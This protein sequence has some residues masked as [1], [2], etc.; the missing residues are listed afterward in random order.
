MAS[1][2]LTIGGV[3]FLEKVNKKSVIWNT[4]KNGRP[5]TLNLQIVNPDSGIEI[6]DEVILKINGE[7]E[8]AGRI[9]RI[10]KNLE[11]I[12]IS[13]LSLE[14]LDYSRD[15]NKGELIAEIYKKQTADY[16]INDLI[17]RYP[18]LSEFTQNNVDCPE[19][20]DY[21]FI[22][23]VN[24]LDTLRKI[25]D[26]TGYDF[27]IDKNKDIH[28]YIVGAENAAFNVTDA[29][30]EYIQGTLNMKET[31]DRIINSMIIEGGLFD[32]TITS[33]ENFVAAVAQVEFDLGSYYSGY[34][35]TV[36]TISKTVGVFGLNEASEYD[37]LYD[38]SGRKIVFSAPLSG[39][40]VI[41]WSG[42][43]KLPVL[44]HVDEPNSIVTH[45]ILSKR[46]IDKSLKTRNSAVQRGLAEL[47][48][49]SETQSNGGFQTLKYGIRAGERIRI[50]N[51]GLGIDEDYVVQDTSSRI[52]DDV[53]ATDYGIF[54]T[55]VNVAKAEV[56][57]ATRILKQLLNE[58]NK[59]VSANEILILHK[60][61]QENIIVGDE[62]LVDNNKQSIDENI[63]IADIVDDAINKTLEWVHAPYFPSS[64]SDSKRQMLHDSTPCH[65]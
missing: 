14:C 63:Q 2:S 52:H 11:S 8:F 36:D 38:F 45:G 20:I 17:T 5:D 39:G 49:Y 22:G 34:S 4:N 18:Q 21:L 12:G 6:D 59:S 55:Q 28:L 65:A 44:V 37:A 47:S 58:K 51:T 25:S 48:K 50:T 29:G 13:K 41:V 30:G 27:Y 16:I 61:F 43:E 60:R 10:N 19:V 1:W 53:N 33:V 23:H 46:L 32:A 35:I 31:G 26:L 3:E 54:V 64:F 9:L 40:E 56:I 7:T 42:I 62:V 57:D 15:A 24:F